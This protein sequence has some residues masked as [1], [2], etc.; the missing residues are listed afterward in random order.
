M[1]LRRWKSIAIQINP[2]VGQVDYGHISLNEVSG[3]KVRGYAKS[4]VGISPLPQPSPLLRLMQ[5]T[6]YPFD[7]SCWTLLALVC[8]ILSGTCKQ[9][10]FEYFEHN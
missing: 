2:L 6:L 1:E 9:C 5:P 8:S 3:K 7:T 4:E 10:F